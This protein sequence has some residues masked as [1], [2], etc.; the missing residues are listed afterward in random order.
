MLNKPYSESCEQNR[1]PI[2]Q[3]VEPLLEDC[4]QL[5]EIGSGTGQHAV[6]FAAAL[7]H[8]IW[9]TSDRQAYHQGIKCWLDEAQLANTRAP[10][11]L[12]VRKDVWPTTMYDAVFSAN[13]LHIMHKDDVKAL[14]AQLS[15]VLKADGL[16]IVYGA[17]N[18][19]GQYTSVSNARFDQWLHAQDPQS[20]IKAFEWVNQL[21]EEAGLQLKQ[22]IPMPANNELICWQKIAS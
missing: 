12:D 18:R 21:A 20:G 10:L 1:A 17:F 5:L 22:T 7:P 6:Y 16:L 9:Q 11:A 13:T 8:L 15:N 19:N 2:F 14:F 4:Q 3:T